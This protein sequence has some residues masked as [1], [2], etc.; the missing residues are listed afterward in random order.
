MGRDGQNVVDGVSLDLLIE[1]VADARS[2]REQVFDRHRFV[3]EWQ[4]VPEHRAGGG[5]EIQPTLFD[6]AH[7]RQSG[8]S[9]GPAGDPEPRVDLV[10]DLPAPMRETVGL[11]ELDPAP[12]DTHDAGERRLGGDQ[13]DGV[14]QAAQSTAASGS[15]VSLASG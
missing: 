8:E 1:V 5:A 11:D 3:D 15:F 2:V 6:Q 7:D 12:V 10:R 4:I 13:I 14:L 9:L